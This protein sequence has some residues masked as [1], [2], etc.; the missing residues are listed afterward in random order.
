MCVWFIVWCSYG[1]WRYFVGYFVIF[2][3]DIVI[4]HVVF[5]TMYNRIEYYLYIVFE[6]MYSSMLYLLYYI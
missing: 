6:T 5:N 2:V 4:L 3:W 1:I